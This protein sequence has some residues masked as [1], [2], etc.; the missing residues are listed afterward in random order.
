M[1]RHKF[2][3][4]RC[5]REGIKFPSKAER[6]YYDKLCLLK[7]SGEILFFLRQVSFD[8]PGGVVYRCDF[9]CF[10]KDGTV[11]IVDVKGYMTP[12]AKNKIAMV[13]DIYPIKITIIEK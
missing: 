12:M 6:A 11:D 1:V 7:K 5:E 9:M 10:Y 4:I 3:A 13:E 8:L 2:G